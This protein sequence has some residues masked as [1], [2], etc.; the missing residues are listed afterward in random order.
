MPIG[1]AS[2][3]LLALLMFAAAAAITLMLDPYPLRAKPPF[4]YD[5]L[6]AAAATE[7]PIINYEGLCK[8]VRWN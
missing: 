6:S 4:S 1:L 2:S 5:V 8:A 3:V 7:P